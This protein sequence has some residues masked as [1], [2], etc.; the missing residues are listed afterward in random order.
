MLELGKLHFI[1]DVKNAKNL[2]DI[3]VRGPT[4]PLHQRGWS[5]KIKSL[6]KRAFSLAERSLYLVLVHSRPLYTGV[7]IW[8]LQ[9]LPGLHHFD[10]VLVEP[11]W[12]DYDKLL[13]NVDK[14]SVKIWSYPLE[15][16]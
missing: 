6:E 1:I 2:A 5:S 8:E 9:L 10:G 14:L 16:T 12:N 11:M 15:L 3:G 13:I 7:S 4:G